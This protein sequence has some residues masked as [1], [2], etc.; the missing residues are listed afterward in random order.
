M[1]L[2][3]ALKNISLEAGKYVPITNSSYIN[4]LLIL[5]VSL[6]LAKIADFIFEKVFL[7]ITAHTETD[8][9]DKIVASLKSPIYFAVLAAGVYA[10]L[11]SI[12]LG[13]NVFYYTDNLIQTAIAIIGSVA[14]WRVTSIL[15]DG[16]VGK[17][18]AKTKSTLDDEMVP[19]L[20]NISK[21]LIIFIA[22][23]AVLSA[24][25][26]N[27]TPLLASAGIVGVALAFAAQSTVANLFGGIAIYFDKPFKV[28]DRIQL[29]SGEIGDVVEVGIRSTRVKTLDDTMIIIPNDK[30]ANAKVI[31][32]NQ[33]VPRMNIKINVGVAYGSDVAKVKETLS[34]VARNSA[35]VLKEPAPAVHF[36]DH[37]DFALKFM[38]TAWIND[39]AK[40]LSAIDEINT[41]ISAEFRKAKIDIPFPTQ[42]IYVSKN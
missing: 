25:D 42:T 11:H 2:S 9:D 37:G 29:D 28:G 31:N 35:S 38:L 41:G 3:D 36:I 32:F 40:K 19:L 23:I 24:W 39:P 5:A 13:E 14:A 4:A 26:I 30:I 1:F 10:S 16:V 12:S 18:A 33:P 7:R 34:K 20:K 17:F 27:I 21:I 15:I 22:I 8:L 6:V